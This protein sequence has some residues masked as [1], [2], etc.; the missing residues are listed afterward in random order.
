[1]QPVSQFAKITRPRNTLRVRAIAQPFMVGVVLLVCVSSLR[2]L[3]PGIETFLRRGAF[4][5]LAETIT[6]I[7]RRVG[8]TLN[9]LWSR[10]RRRKP[11]G[12]LVMLFATLI[13]LPLPLLPIQILW[14]NSRCI[15]RTVFSWLMIAG[16][17]LSFPACNTSKATID[18]TI[19]FFSSTSPG[20][21]FTPDGMVE[22][23]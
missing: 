1:M 7:E 15:Q 2:S 20:S 10:M 21:M 17:C 3:A 14:M 6:E 23:N 11:T 16:L 8:E 22:Q 18:T 19:K 9:R 13:G 4:S 12:A 5:A